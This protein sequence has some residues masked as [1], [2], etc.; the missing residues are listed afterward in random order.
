MV[1]E[2]REEIASPRP[3]GYSAE[4]KRPAIAR[5]FSRPTTNLDPSMLHILVVEDN[6]VNQKV[7]V[8]Q[9]TKAGCTV[10]AANNGVEALVHLA[11][12]EFQ[13]PA[14][15]KLS[16]ILMDLEMP[17]MDGLTCVRRIREMERIG[18]L[19]GH[20]PTIAVTAN[21]REEQIREARDAGMDDVVSKPFRIPELLAKVEGLLSK[22][23]S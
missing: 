16:V 12:T 9:L 1:A 7:L 18:T 20:V 5:T 13:V 4:K 3:R 22:V 15:R 23:G 19:S 14:G 11:G 2:A 8:K 17:E 21:V 6:L 10:R